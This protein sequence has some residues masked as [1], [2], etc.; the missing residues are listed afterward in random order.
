MKTCSRFCGCYS[1]VKRR[2]AS[3]KTRDN[4]LA[5][6]KELYKITYDST[7]NLDHCWGILKDTPKWQATQQE[8]DAKLKKTKAP[9][10]STSRPATNAN[11]VSA[12]DESNTT[13]SVSAPDDLG[14][15]ESDLGDRRVLGDEGRP[16]GNKAAKRKRNEEALLEKVIKMQESLVKTAEERTALVKAAMESAEEHRT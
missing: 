11:S 1:Q 2:L 13:S 14:K 4:V 12:A 8:H 6:A 5:E 10:E 16:D 3:G 9:K 7:F 15:E